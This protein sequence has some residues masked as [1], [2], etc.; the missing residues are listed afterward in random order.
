MSAF[1]FV[2]YCFFTN[3]E[4]ILKNLSQS[5]S[6]GAVQRENSYNSL[7]AKFWYPSVDSATGLIKI[8]GLLLVEINF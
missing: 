2:L 6:V 1:I 7:N 8:D 4:R 5:A 3:K